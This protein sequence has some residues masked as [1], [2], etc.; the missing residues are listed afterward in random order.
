MHR[1]MESGTIQDLSGR[2]GGRPVSNIPV[3]TCAS[4]FLVAR[5]RLKKSK[6]TDEEETERGASLLL[7]VF[8]RREG[9]LPF[10]FR[11]GEKDH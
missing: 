11:R 8:V 6:H 5:A 4:I 1:L 7:V 9:S 10:G 2:R 3:R